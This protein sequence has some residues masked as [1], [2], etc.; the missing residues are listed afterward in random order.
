MQIYLE[1]LV[2]FPGSVHWAHDVVASLDNCTRD[3]PDLV[4][5]VQQLSIMVKEATVDKVVA[6]SKQWNMTTR[7][8]VF[9]I[10]CI[11]IFYVKLV[12]YSLYMKNIFGLPLS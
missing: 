8:D 2:Q 7:A 3:V 5:I 6:E 10:T 9:I 12:G 4:H 11:H 1:Y